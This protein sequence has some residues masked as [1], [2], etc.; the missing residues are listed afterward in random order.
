M[1]FPEFLRLLLFFCGAG[2]VVLSIASLAIPRVLGWKKD[3]AKLKPLTRE[4]FWTY[5]AYILGTNFC[6]GILSMVGPRWL[7]DG[8]PLAAAVCGF[9]AVYWGARIAIQFFYFDRKSAPKGKLYI[10]GE[11]ALVSLFVVLTIT[12]AAA[13]VFNLFRL[14][15]G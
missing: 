3:L 4:V 8:T 11:I 5:A 15:T 2:Q 13:L 9:I 1:S 14:S 10:L 12:Y 6:F 7:T